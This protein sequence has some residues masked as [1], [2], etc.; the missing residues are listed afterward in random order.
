[1]PPRPRRP[2]PDPA[3]GC[4][5]CC[6][7]CHCQTW[8]WSARSE[9]LGQWNRALTIHFPQA[10]CIE[11]WGYPLVAGTAMLYWKRVKSFGRR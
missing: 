10:D 5:G 11:C 1:R 3:G 9:Q 2:R 4:P 7:Y 6:R 8:E